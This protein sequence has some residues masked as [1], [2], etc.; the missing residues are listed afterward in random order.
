MHELSVLQAV[1]DELPHQIPEGGELRRLELRVG[2]LEHLDSQVMQSG[3]AALTQGTKYAGSEL[4]IRVVPVR[5]RCRSCE[6]EYRPDDVSILI[7][8]DC[9]RAY[10]EVLDGAGL[11]LQALH[12]TMPDENRTTGQSF[13]GG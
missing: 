1:L 11:V 3:W 7:C 2:A 12:V 10:P 6:R 9:G 5:V 8:P 4:V 13:A